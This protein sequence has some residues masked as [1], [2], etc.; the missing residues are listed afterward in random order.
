MPRK[1]QSNPAISAQHQ[2]EQ[3]SEG[4]ENYELPKSI[5]T[6]IA[7]SAIPDNAKLQKEFVLALLKGSTVFINYLGKLH[8]QTFNTPV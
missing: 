8:N 1:D 2:Q 6:R 3:V 7:K 5:V 4:I